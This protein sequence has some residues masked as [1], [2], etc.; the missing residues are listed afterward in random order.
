MKSIKRLLVLMLVALAFAGSANAQLRFGVKAGLNLNSLHIDNLADNLSSDNGCGFTG[1][2]M[3]EFT[4]P[5]IGLGFDASLM[6]TRMNSELFSEPLFSDN[7]TEVGNGNSKDFFEIPVNVK[8]KFS[9]PAVGNVVSPYLFTGPSFAFKLGG[10]DNVFATKK[11]QCAWNVGVG[12]ELINHLQISGSYGFG[13]NNIAKDYL[14]MEVTD[15]YK[16]KNNYWTVT[17]AWLF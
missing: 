15:D 16:V 13:M 5:V 7:G 8:Y 11:F 9:I 14:G 1:G 17:A 2:V 6:Y 12:I 3:A 10:D 4:L